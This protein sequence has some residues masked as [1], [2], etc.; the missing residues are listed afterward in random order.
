MGGGIQLAPDTLRYFREPSK[1]EG[2]EREEKK[3]GSFD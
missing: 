2:G 1:R 3:A